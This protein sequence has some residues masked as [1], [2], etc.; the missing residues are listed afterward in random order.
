MD[1]RWQKAE[2]DTGIPYY[3][4]HLSERTQ[5]DHPEYV[6]AQRIMDEMGKIQ[7]ASYRA[8]MKIRTLQKVINL[9]S[10]ELSTITSVFEHFGFN[11]PSNMVMNVIQLQDVVYEVFYTTQCR[12]WSS[13]DVDTSTDLMVNWT[14]NLFDMGRTGFLKVLSVKILMVVL[15]SAELSE[16]YQYLYEQLTDRAGGVSR[17]NMT[18][19]LRDM[20]RITELIDESSALGK[21]AAAAVNSCFATVIGTTVSH[22]RYMSWLM[23]E[24]QTIVW[25]PTMY[26]VSLAESVRH[27]AKCN[28]CKMFPIIG[29]RFK[30]LK[31]LNYDMCQDCFFVARTTKRHKLTHPTQEYIIATSSKEDIRDFAKTIRNKM[32]KKHGRR[33]KL[34]YLPV[35]DSDTDSNSYC[36]PT[37]KEIDMHVRLG[38]I[39]KKLAA[40]EDM[41]P[42][43]PPSTEASLSPISESI[44]SS[45][46]PDPGSALARGQET[47]R[48]RSREH[49]ELEDLIDI[50]ERENEELLIDMEELNMAGRRMAS[51]G[52]GTSHEAHD[53]E[54]ESIG[55]S[56]TEEQQEMMIAR[57]EVLEDQNRQLNLQLKTLKSL[58]QK[59]NRTPPQASTSMFVPNNHAPPPPYHAT[60]TNGHLD[61]TAPPGLPY[62]Q[63]ATQSQPSIDMIDSQHVN[64]SVLPTPTANQSGASVV[65][66]GSGSLRPPFMLDQ[67]VTPQVSLPPH[68]STNLTMTPG[69]SDS[70]VPLPPYSS[71][72]SAMTPGTFAARRLL[73][74]HL[75]DQSTVMFPNLS[76]SRIYPPEEAA[77]NDIV[78][79]MN[80]AYPT[81]LQDTP[82]SPEMP[83]PPSYTAAPTFMRTRRSH[84]N[85]DNPTDMIDAVARIGDAMSYLVARV[86]DRPSGM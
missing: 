86:A 48:D 33:V 73:P 62:Y 65:M 55:T 85:H 49:R 41:K 32:S 83:P 22:D 3:I 63:P 54:D 78:Q 20:I 59:Q 64:S 8:A 35:D 80:E 19:F 77:L 43:P 53:L 17:R 24:P 79:R 70:T 14:L 27:D 28:I 31:C 84:G 16:K 15:C 30:C 23:A 18:A 9:H 69:L 57:H 51:A 45:M 5:W 25:L 82:A 7:L 39:S 21:N 67:L 56:E 10:V 61:R 42:A 46:I 2:T 44:P 13:L 38:H 52:E 74:A 66:S 34:K 58:L 72:Q 11:S 1:K 47:S 37:D 36:D 26:R 40:V 4:N 6:K 71:N 60:P 50:L 75:V 12:G 68:H 81:N 29:L 76:A